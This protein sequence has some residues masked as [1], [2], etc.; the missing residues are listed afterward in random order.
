MGGHCL[1]THV[2]FRARLVPSSSAGRQL[3]ASTRLTVGSTPARN[4]ALPPCR[5]RSHRAHVHQRICSR[6]RKSPAIRGTWC[7]D[8]SRRTFT[9]RFFVSA[10]RWSG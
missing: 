7:A 3:P 6:K 4:R 1:V 10:K 5:A 8:G 9:G 2:G